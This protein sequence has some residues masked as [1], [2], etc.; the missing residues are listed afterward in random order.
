M[1]EK[2]YR[3]RDDHNL[4]DEIVK[5]QSSEMK[6]KRGKNTYSLFH[7]MTFRHAS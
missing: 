4:S 5:S 3:P 2:G 7:A 1:A 6:K